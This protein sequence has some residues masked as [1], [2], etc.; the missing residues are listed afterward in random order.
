MGNRMPT[1]EPIKIRGYRR[2]D[3]T[4][5]PEH[6]QRRNRNRGTEITP[7]G[8]R[9]VLLGRIERARAEGRGVR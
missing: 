6:W 4:F 5:V 8:D 7:A 9:E 2:S 1:Y 3:G